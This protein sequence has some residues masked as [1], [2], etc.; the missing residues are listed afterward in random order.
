MCDLNGDESFHNQDIVESRRPGEDIV[1]EHV[2]LN[3][4]DT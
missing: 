1:Q 4:R 3:K 2:V